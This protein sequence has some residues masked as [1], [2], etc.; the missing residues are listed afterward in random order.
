VRSQEF[1]A[2]AFWLRYSRTLASGSNDRSGIGCGLSE[3]VATN[4]AWEARRMNDAR[5][6]SVF[7]AT[8]I[9]H[10]ARRKWMHPERSILEA[11]LASI[12]D[13]EAHGR[14]RAS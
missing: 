10:P 13:R 11:C 7:W 2:G 4:S 3:K 8:S 9:R 12:M 5:R 14:A 1:G 6:A